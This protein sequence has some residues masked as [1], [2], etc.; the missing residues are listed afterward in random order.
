MERMEQIVQAQMPQVPAQPARA[1]VEPVRNQP[2][3]VGM[4]EKA[5]LKCRPKDNTPKGGKGSGRN[6]V[7]WDKNC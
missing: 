7:P 5:N 4:A 6:F 2:A 1:S 3:Q